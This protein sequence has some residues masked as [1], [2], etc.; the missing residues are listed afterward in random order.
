MYTA[1]PI[2]DK[3]I[4]YSITYKNVPESTVTFKGFADAA[5]VDQEDGKLTTSYVFIA[6]EGAIT[7]QS[8]KQT[9]TTQSSTEAEYIALWEAG[10]ETS[11][12]RNL[13][14]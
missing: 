14:R 7:W 10:K 6:A 2:R 5:Y 3:D 1:I 11:W 12:L 4:Q 8:G 13:Y 9:I